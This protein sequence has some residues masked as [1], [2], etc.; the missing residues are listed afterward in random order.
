LRLEL[1][2]DRLAPALVTWSGGGDGTSWL[3]SHNWQGN[4]LP[5]ASDDAVINLP[6]TFTVR[7]AGGST[8]IH[9]LQSARALTI[10][11][12]SLTLTAGA[13][14]VDNALTVSPNATFVVNGG[15]TSFTTTATTT[16]DGANLYATGGA[17]L[18]LP[19]LT[20]YAGSSDATTLQAS[21]ANSLLDLSHLTT[22]R[23]GSG[24]GAVS[25]T[26][27]AGGRVDLRG[28]TANPGGRTVVLADGANSVVDLS[29][30]PH[31]VSDAAYNSS[32]QASNGGTVNL[33]PGT[34]TLS[35]VDLNVTPTGTLTAGTL[36]LAAGSTLTGTG[37]I[38]A[39]VSN[40]GLV[41]PGTSPSN[42]GILTI[43][44][45]Y[46]QTAGGSLTVDIGGLGD[47]HYGRLAVTGSVALGGT[48]N[49]NLV[50]PYFPQNGDTFSILIFPSASGQFAT[51]NGL[52]QSGGRRTFQPWD[53]PTELDLVTVL[54][55][56]YPDLQVANLAVTP[57]T[58]LHSGA[59]LT[60]QWDDI[61]TGLAATDRSWSDLV[62]IKNLTTGATLVSTTVFYNATL[63]GPLGV[64]G[65]R[66]RQ[67]AFTLPNGAA[68]AGD[69]QFTVTV[70]VFHDVFEFNDAGTAETNNTAALKR[71]STQPSSLPDLQVLNLSVEPASGAQSGSNLV[72]HWSTANTGAA[73]T[74]GSFYDYLMVKNTTT[75][76][77]LIEVPLRYDEAAPGNGPIAAGDQRARQY[78]FRLPD[79]PAGAGHIEFMVTTDYYQ[80]VQVLNR[81]HG[82]AM[83]ALDV[84]LAAYPDLQ[85]TGLS[86]DAATGLHSGAGLV[87]HWNDSNTG[88]G[89]TN[90]PWV[91]RVVIT[92]LTTNTVLVSATL[93]YDA[94]ARGP[95]AAGGLQ[96][97]QYAFTLP[98]GPAGVGQIQFEVTTNVTH[99][100]FEYNPSGNAYSNNTAR[101]T[102]ASTLTAYPDLAVTAITAT[103][104]PGRQVQLAWTVA[105]LG[106]APAAGTWTDQVFV[107]QDRDINHAL[108][109]GSFP[110][111]GPL[112]AGQ[113]VVRGQTIALPAGGFS[114][115]DLWFIVRTDS[116]NQ[117]FELN[118]DNNTRVADQPFHVMASLALGLSAT[119]VSE[120][121]DNP[122]LRGTVSRNG[123]L[124][125]PL[126]VSLTSSATSHLTVPATVTIPAG[127]ASVSFPIN[128]IHDGLVT[129][130]QTVTITAQAAGLD[131]DARTVL[132]LDVDRPSLTVVLAAGQIAEGATSPATTGTVTRNTP[133]TQALVVTLGSSDP[134]RLR[135]P[136]TVTIAAGQLSATFSVDAPDDGLIDGTES[137]TV[138]A[139]APG[140]S[141]GSAAVAVADPDV[142][143]LR[144]T[145]AAASVLKNATSPA[146]TGTVTRDVAGNQDLVVQLESSDP[147]RLVVPAQVTIPA[148]RASASFP[149]SVVNSP[150]SDGPETVAISAFL[151]TS[152]NGT[153]L[154]LGSGFATIDVLDDT[155]PVL[156]VALAQAAAGPGATVRGTVSRNASTNA[157]LVVNLVSSN[158]AGATVPAT[159]TIPAGQA[160]AAFSITTAAPGTL[161]GTQSVTISASAEGLTDGAA[162]LVVTDLSLPDLQVRSVVV[163]SS[164]LT[165]AAFNVTY[166][167]VN[168]GTGPAA[169]SW[170]DRV[171]LANSAQLAGAQLLGEL[172]FTGTVPVG[173][174]Y[175]RT[176]PFFLP[177]A[178]GDYWVFVTTN[179]TQTVAEAVTTNN[180]TLSSQPIHVAPAYRATVSADLRMGVAGTP[181][182]LHGRAFRTDTGAAAPFVTVT[183]RIQLR[184]TRRVLTVLTDANGNFTTVFQ[185]LPGEAGHYLVGADHPQVQQDPVQDEFS[186]VGL[187]ASPATVAQQLIE[188]TSV[189][190]QVSLENL[191][192]VPLSGLRATVLNVPGNLQ[193]SV[194]LAATLPGSGAIPLSYQITARDATVPQSTVTVHVSSAE[195][196]S[197]DLPLQVTVTALRPQLVTNPASLS[198]GVLRGQQT[199]LTFTVTNT[200]GVATGPVTVALPSIAWLHLSS[201]SPMP[202]LAPGAST[203]VTLQLTP[204][205][206]LALGEYRGA[207][208]LSGAGLSLSV[209]FSFQAISEAVGDLAVTATDEYTYFVSGAPKVAGA[210]VTV[211]DPTTGALV[212]QGLT[213]ASGRLL[214]PRLREGYYNLK[215]E[216][217]QHGQFSS[218][219]KIDAGQTNDVQ[220][221][222]PRQTASYNWTVT[223]TEIEGQTQITLDTTFET[224]VPIPVVTISPATLDLSTLTQPT[225]Q[226]DLTITNH[227]LIAAQDVHLTFQN[228]ILYEFTPLIQD[229]NVLP[230]NSALTVPVIIKKLRYPEQSI[231]IPSVA[232]VRHDEDPGNPAP[233]PVTPVTAQPLALHVPP[234]T[235][236][237]TMIDVP[238]IITA[239][240]K[241]LAASMPTRPI[242]G[243]LVIEIRRGP[244]VT[245]ISMIPGG[246]LTAA[247]SF[248][249]S[250]FVMV[251]HLWRCALI[252]V[253]QMLPSS[254]RFRVATGT[255]NLMVATIP[256]RFTNPLDREITMVITTGIHTSI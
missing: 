176:V 132:V 51:I 144:V 71:T 166:Q 120:D 58:Q 86:V 57:A 125:Q 214:L 241:R 224:N 153:R 247:A 246:F 101:I 203:T 126:T 113:E 212:V 29:N 36:A 242:S 220:A 35:W 244:L 33:T 227:G 89:A 201:P 226:V 148:G 97:Q 114:A 11:S 34:I 254:I 13:S 43:A 172:P 42:P 102:Q 25:V 175:G 6:G 128:A 136:A 41:R 9:S 188:G 219:I 100:L 167:I 119:T 159:V 65:S 145:L 62:E 84:P 69:I 250:K 225:T 255:S 142:P 103:A 20:S 106:N 163:P 179:A 54:D 18:A 122:A 211:S 15:T 154:Q 231:T 110:Y 1:L 164:G 137:V 133:A 253:D 32:L 162:T 46:T 79:G 26:A 180:T 182:P 192:D 39:N 52:L 198:A 66:P 22:L 48:L 14:E 240:N 93:A 234:E 121:A 249:G 174:G 165:G 229:I 156:Q 173:Q 7:Y 87:V 170:V 151:T 96:A 202:S 108:S 19:S 221:F 205:A 118:K 238:A 143:Q 141:G 91:D 24:Y 50:S 152:M 147:S 68:G 213:D 200:G 252:T 72:V 76:Q 127:L 236:G 112:N 215:V 155:G 59:S 47:G 134:T 31:L 67:F 17:V 3:D 56:N 235:G 184:D 208:V 131:G 233:S 177:Q 169:G 53:R 228:N 95:I 161:H 138:Y 117:V 40:G 44:G 4:V 218:T 207:L 216:A 223:P 245:S 168:Q 217:D 158:S 181:V 85:V 157:P 140:F 49:V 30:L 130:D 16:V 94:L 256:N 64:G 191:G 124:S 150:L 232:F 193:V 28:L 204:A 99:A 199:I 92:N 23:G 10:A 129:G 237:Y 77:T 171:Y 73:A 194:A 183:V 243:S 146:T 5:G 27:A 81:D 38:T 185:P 123:D 74:S 178:P 88:N 45:N 190:G 82:T 189:T 251:I 135:L 105:N 63:N 116:T 195:G 197:V 75:N 12:G 98:D 61:N 104:L 187:R 70:N 2:E 55:S 149:V 186:L 80:Q 239:S 115:G 111:S 8:S 78:A 196:A 60:V 83:V 90:G 21:G 160:S 222:L 107:S 109:L 37:T 248:A 210:K 139:T 230:A 209:P 206:T